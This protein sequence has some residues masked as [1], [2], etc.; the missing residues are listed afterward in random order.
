MHE[1]TYKLFCCE[2]LINVDV[3]I[4][5]ISELNTTGNVIIGKNNKY[6]GRK[7]DHLPSYKV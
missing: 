6:T 4:I 3:S 2:H 1:D 7:K 5:C